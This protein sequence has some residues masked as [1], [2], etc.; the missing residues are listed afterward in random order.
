VPDL[1]VRPYEPAD[2]SA[3]HRIAADTA[4]FGQPVEAFL[5]DRRLF[6]DLLYRYYTDLEPEHGWVAGEE[7]EIAGFLMG[8]VDTAVQQCRWRREILPGVAWRMLRGGYRL[9]RLTWRYLI[10]STV[11]HLRQEAPSVDLAAYPAHLHVNVDARWRGHGLGQRLLAAGLEQLRQLD[12]PG[13]HLHTTSM[14][15]AACRLYVKRGF[16]LLEERR[17]RLW[18]HLVDRPVENRCYGLIL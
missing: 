2:R 18:A 5:E 14:N 1:T 6:C 15:E 8:C 13:V 7:E 12:V 17:T 3:V 10:A 9:G 4:F 16:R 11:A